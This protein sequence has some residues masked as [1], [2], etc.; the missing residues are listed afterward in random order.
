MNIYIQIFL[1]VYFPL[2]IP[3]L[4]N[5]IIESH[6]ENIWTLKNLNSLKKIE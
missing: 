1:K 4:S 3:Y 5:N 6:I 2:I